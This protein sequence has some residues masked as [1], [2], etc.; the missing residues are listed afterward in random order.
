MGKCLIF[1]LNNICYCMIL[2]RFIFFINSYDLH[3]H[4][5]KVKKVVGNPNP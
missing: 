3:D 1:M 5:L 4:S 2:Y